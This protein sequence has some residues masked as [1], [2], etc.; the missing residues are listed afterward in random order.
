LTLLLT[1]VTSV[2]LAIVGVAAAAPE[3]E[4]PEIASRV[5]DLTNV[6]REKAGLAP[7]V[8]SPEL[9]QSAQ[10][11]SQLL[12]SSGCFDHTCGPVPNFIDRDG[13]AGYT[14]WTALG[15]NLAAGYATP[16]E[17]VAGWMGS[18]GHRDNILSPLYTEVGI[19]WA[20][21]SGRFKWY[22]AQEFGARPDS[23]GD[24]AED[25]SSG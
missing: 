14:G 17:V 13:F 5:F 12:A 4:P 20:K 6:E 22:W 8:F 9:E 18:P 15:E 19:G 1:G 23:G 16:E 7:L 11:Y 25:G 21:G 24:G 3:D 2:A 10:S